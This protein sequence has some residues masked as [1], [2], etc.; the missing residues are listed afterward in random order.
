[1]S[2]LLFLGLSLS[3]LFSV[4]N[5]LARPLHVYR[6]YLRS[7][8]EDDN[9]VLFLPTYVFV[10]IVLIVLT[11]ISTI[12]FALWSLTTGVGVQVLAFGGLI[13]AAFRL[14]YLARTSQLKVAFVNGSMTIEYKGSWEYREGKTNSVMERL[15]IAAAVASCLYLMYLALTVFQA[16]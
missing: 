15:N 11:I 6:S 5:L 2:V 9:N 13:A 16:R 3:M 8:N 12:F 7:L 1:M 4:Y 10:T 14:A